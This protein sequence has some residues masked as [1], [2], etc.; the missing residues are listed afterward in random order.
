MDT[1]VV[2][3]TT[4]TKTKKRKR[5]KMKHMDLLLWSN[6]DYI[7][8]ANFKSSPLD[9][10]SRYRGCSIFARFFLQEFA[11]KDT[12]EKSCQVLPK[13]Y[14]LQDFLLD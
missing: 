13:L 1:A 2:K 6:L 3:A 9:S 14:S 5:K 4:K 11:H 7:L 8:M 10:R 12:P